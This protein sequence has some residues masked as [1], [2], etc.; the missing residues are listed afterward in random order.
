MTS[1]LTSI[2]TNKRKKTPEQLVSYTKQTLINL[3]TAIAAVEQQQQLHQQAVER[4]RSSSTA[5]GEFVMVDNRTEKLE[6][7]VDTP[8][9]TT[10]TV[11]ATNSPMAPPSLQ[12]CATMS[13]SSSFTFPIGTPGG[14]SAP[15]P[16][17]SRS[18]A[19]SSCNDLTAGLGGNNI[20]GLPPIEEEKERTSNGTGS[21]TMSSTGSGSNS[22]KTSS[23]THSG[24]MTSG[25]GTPSGTS[26]NNNLSSVNEH[27]QT[28][29]KS[30]IEMKTILYGDI[31]HQSI[32]DE[33]CR[34][35]SKSFQSIDLIPLLI[36]SLHRIPFESRKDIASIFHQLMKKD[37][38]NFVSYFTQSNIVSM[39]VK[40][41]VLGYSHCDIA[42][43]C[44]MILRECIKY[45]VIARY[46]LMGETGTSATVPATVFPAVPPVPVNVPASVPVNVHTVPVSVPASA[47][48]AT[49]IPVT[50]GEG[51]NKIPIEGGTT[52]STVDTNT[53]STKLSPPSEGNGSMTERD[54]WRDVSDDI[55]AKDLLWQFFDTYVHLPN[56]DIASDAFN[57]MK[58]LLTTPKN[59]QIAYDFI[60]RYG[61][62]LLRKYEVS[63]CVFM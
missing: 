22:A 5:D 25:S 46:I 49:T 2:N 56:F 61:E 35:L 4:M 36:R 40:Y 9:T 43:T 63:R 30:L 14:S 55:D 57:T 34:E 58:D 44:G 47:S 29:S 26:S 41:L 51:E 33:K 42:L 27:T 53:T 12:Q 52:E 54:L 20:T 38:A 24:K 59:K 1:F 18:R 23:L 7:S 17:Q 37:I 48:A 60:E 8:V 32:D 21:G 62:I 13:I 50:T 39:T 15:T 31:D 16:M 19:S 6:I 28:L 45:D 11:S 3:I 10:S